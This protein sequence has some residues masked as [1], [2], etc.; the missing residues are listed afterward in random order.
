MPGD[1]S[2]RAPDRMTALRELELEYRYLS[3]VEAEAR[4]ARV[5][6]L[7]LLMRDLKANM[8]EFWQREYPKE[9]I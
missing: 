8:R 6:W 7:V 9:A 1:V 3:A 4:M 5:G 2:S